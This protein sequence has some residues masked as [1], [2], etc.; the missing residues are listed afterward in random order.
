MDRC[1]AVPHK[2]PAFV[3]CFGNVLSS[4]LM[5]LS[6]YSHRLAATKAFDENGD[7]GITEKLVEMQCFCTSFFLSLYFHRKSQKTNKNLKKIAV[8][9]SADGET[10]GLRLYIFFSIFFPYTY[11]HSRYISLDF[12]EGSTLCFL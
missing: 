6:L 1:P 7:G 8:S 3:H 11:I 12:W 10:Q 2:F 4:N 9:A 5:F